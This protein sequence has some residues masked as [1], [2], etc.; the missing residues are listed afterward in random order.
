M[1][2]IIMALKIHR[3]LHYACSAVHFLVLKITGKSLEDHED[4]LLDED[5]KLG[6]K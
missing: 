4:K 2:Y 6:D 5:E 1:Q 3:W